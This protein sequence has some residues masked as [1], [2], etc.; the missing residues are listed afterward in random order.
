MTNRERA[1]LQTF[2]DWYVFEGSRQ[3][4][5]AQIGEAV[6]PLASN[7]IATAVENVVESLKED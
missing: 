6:P 1:R 2:P 3:E 4:V 7:K 5:R